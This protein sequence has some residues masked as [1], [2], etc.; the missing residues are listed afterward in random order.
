MITANDC[1]S[2]QQLQAELTAALDRAARAEADNE[3]LRE[4]LSRARVMIG[5][6]SAFGDQRRLLALCMDIDATLEA[7]G[8]D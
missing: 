4:R 6:L 7:A 5:E 1:L 8:E 3:S 2:C